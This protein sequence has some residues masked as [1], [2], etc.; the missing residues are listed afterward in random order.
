MFTLSDENLFLI[1]LG[2]LTALGYA[3][4][5]VGMKLASTGVVWSAMAFMAVG[6]MIAAVAEVV[7][8]QR[9]A[10]SLVYVVIIAMET[11]LVLTFALS[12]GEDLTSRQVAGAAFVLVGLALTIG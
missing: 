9:H 5:T 10:V 1:A 2:L 6:F 11:F 7:L 3:A 4:A 12:I 8:M